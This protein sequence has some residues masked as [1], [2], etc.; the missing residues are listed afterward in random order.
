MFFSFFTSPSLKCWILSAAYVP[1]CFITLQKQTQKSVVGV[2]PFCG[3]KNHADK[4]KSEALPFAEGCSTKLCADAGPSAGLRRADN[5]CI[6][7]Q[8][9]C[10]HEETAAM[11]KPVCLYRSIHCGVEF[12]AWKFIQVEFTWMFRRFRWPIWSLRYWVKK[13]FPISPSHRELDCSLFVVVFG[14]SFSSS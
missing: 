5:K 4:S 8:R 2:Q 12:G 3:N 13:V 7:Q 9:C 1:V 10:K 14:I 6:H 11:Q